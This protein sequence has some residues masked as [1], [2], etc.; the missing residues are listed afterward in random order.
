MLGLSKVTKQIRY[1]LAP[2]E[3]QTEKGVKL[4]PN[5]SKRGKAPMIEGEERTPQMPGLVSVVLSMLVSASAM[6]SYSV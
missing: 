5:A 4:P 3:E 1:D 2:R 6:S